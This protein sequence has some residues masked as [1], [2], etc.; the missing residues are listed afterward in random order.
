M[1][2][3]HDGPKSNKAIKPINLGVSSKSL[4]IHKT[5]KTHRG[6]KILENRQPLLI[7]NPKTSIFVKGN[8]SSD[9]I[10]KVLK[11]LHLLRGDDKSK[12]FL[13]KTHDIHPF[14]DQAPLEVMAQRQDC[15][16]FC[17]GNNQ[18]KRPNN[19]VLGRTF[20]GRVLDMFE[21]GVENFKAKDIEREL[22][23]VLI[24]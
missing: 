18:K 7:E 15:S 1:G 17:F 12:L 16:L 2:K 11:D 22:K 20:D 5:A 21:F 10:N 23:P 8:K 19:L 14:D 24:F 4:A 3:Q 6:R 9:V 13:K